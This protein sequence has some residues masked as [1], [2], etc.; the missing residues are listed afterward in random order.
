[1]ERTLFIDVSTFKDFS[2][3]IDKQF[4]C[5]AGIWQQ[6]DQL[7]GCE[8]EQL[9]LAE[10]YAEPQLRAS[11]I[12]LPEI[13]NS[14][15]EYKTKPI[16]LMVR[17]RLPSSSY[18]TPA[19]ESEWSRESFGDQSI[20]VLPG[21]YRDPVEMARHVAGHLNDSQQPFFVM[22]VTAVQQKLEALRVI[23]PR[24][25]A[26][27]S[28]ACNGDPVLARILANNE[29]V[30][31]EVA[32]TTE[33]EMAS[34]HIEPSRIVLRSQLLT[35]K[36]IRQTT[37]FGCGTIVI[38][39]EKQLQDVFSSAPLSE[40][41]IAINLQYSNAE[42]PFGCQIEEFEQ[43]IEL[44][45]LIGAKVTG[46]HLELGSNSTLSDYCNMIHD[47]HNIFELASRK[48]VDLRKLS[49]GSFV[50]PTNNEQDLVM[51]CSTINR[52]ISYYF[53]EKVDVSAN[54]GCFLVTNAFTLCT[55]VI[56]KQQMDA[57]F[58]TNDDFDDGV[59]FVYQT[60]DGV[61]GSFGCRQ[62]N[63]NPFCKPLDPSLNDEPLHFGTIIGPSLDQIDIAQNLTKCRQLRVGEWLVWEKMG[64]FTIP[65]DSEYPVPPVYYYSR[66]ECW[67]KLVEKDEQRRSP[68]PGF[69]DIGSD[70]GDSTSSGDDD[71]M[72]GSNMFLNL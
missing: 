50:I 31:F 23:C 44:A 54:V 26:T 1:M 55:N 64:A 60:N 22:D 25:R 36:T 34:A 43:L 3:Q 48:Y 53:D 38:E 62:M 20:A 58:I 7:I 41:L 8:V 30:N 15:F 17:H 11:Q 29:D 56:G 42:I 10:I 6:A 51:F 61:Y 68:S 57:K 18:Y 28:V 63:I 2:V 66:K 70:C 69:D 59:G 16:N 45:H 72:F 24:I 49:F 40:I 32:N 52:T 46:I 9:A 67:Q 37:E 39:T 33:L 27:Y 35:R 19:G 12:R 71:S 5:S 14:F 4:R 13:L 21:E 47:A 65:V